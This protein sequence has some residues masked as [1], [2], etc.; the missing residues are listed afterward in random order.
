MGLQ[1]RDRV[2]VLRL[3]D[4]VHFLL[5]DQ[6]LGQLVSIHLLSVELVPN[7]VVF[8][9]PV[10]GAH[11][12]CKVF[13][14]NGAVTCIGLRRA[15]VQEEASAGYAFVVVGLLDVSQDFALLLGER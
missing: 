7:V 2:S 5:L 3:T 11:L 1:E 4:D 14:L 15:L 10:L 13:I 12:N 9:G 6:G 8:K